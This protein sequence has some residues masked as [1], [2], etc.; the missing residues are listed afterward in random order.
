M[1]MSAGTSPFLA[2]WVPTFLSEWSLPFSLLS[3]AAVF[4]VFSLFFPL[5]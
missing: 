1:L 2:H 4:C 5:S 3:F